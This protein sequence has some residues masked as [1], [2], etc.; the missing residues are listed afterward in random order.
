MALRLALGQARLVVF[1]Y[2]AVTRKI[3]WVRSPDSPQYAGNPLSMDGGQVMA[4]YKDGTAS[5]ITDVCAFEPEEG[6]GLQY[7]GELNIIASY[8]DHSGNKFTADT[9]IEVADVDELIFVGLSNTVQKEGT[10]LD[11]TGVTIRAKYTD[12]TTRDIDISSVTFEPA[13]GEWIGHM[14]TLPIQ[15][16]WQNPMTGSEYSAQYDL[17]VDAVDK[18]F[19]TH[20]PN[21]T[22]YAEGEALDLTG[23]AVALKYKKSGDMEAVTANCSFKPENGAVLPSY[24][25]SIYATYTL[26]S[27]EE[28]SCETLVNVTPSTIPISEI[29]P[30]IGEDLGLEF[31]PDMP[32]DFWDDF[33][34]DFQPQDV[35]YFPV[36]DDYYIPV[37]VYDDI[38]DY[39]N[40][41]DAFAEY[42][43]YG[44]IPYMVLPAGEYV[45]A[46][47][48]NSIKATAD[49]YIIA[50]MQKKNGKPEQLPAPSCVDYPYTNLYSYNQ[51]QVLTFTL[52]SSDYIRCEPGL[53]GGYNSA[54]SGICRKMAGLGLPDVSD[55]TMYTDYVTFS[56]DS[57]VN[58]PG[59]LS[60]PWCWYDDVPHNLSTLKE[61]VQKGE[62]K[63]GCTGITHTGKV[64]YF[65]YSQGS[66]YNEAREQFPEVY[67]T[68]VS[69]NGEEYVHV[70]A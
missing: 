65:T 38:L 25:T 64:P 42:E 7:A 61:M 20:D 46:N 47:G 54:T 11:L 48:E 28:Y 30:I 14:D 53:K 24:G 4:Y 9:S 70:K 40:E 52:N 26:E 6:S 35:P 2:N 63:A 56:S 15:A 31:D 32:D 21:K 10:A 36:D 51:I 18:L 39:L 23:A 3:E 66:L 58:I 60:L 68:T 8:T 41:K 45:S 57:I 69:Y 55:E 13:E 67:P 12:N 44:D 27:G 49:I 43:Q 16:T 33:W 62:S 22:D 59:I 5:D 37:D 50:T 29:G 17:A 34:S 19:F 1:G